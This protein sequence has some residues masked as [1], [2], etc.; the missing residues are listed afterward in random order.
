MPL[1]IGNFKDATITITT[2]DTVSAEVD[3]GNDCD[4][5]QV[6]MPALT[7]CKVSVQVA[8]KTGGTFQ[9]LGNSQATETTAGSYSTMFKLGGY[10]Y[11]KLVTSAGQSGNRT[12]RVR[13]AKS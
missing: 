1:Y 6:I 11:I 3:L 13:G 2:S 9:S 7:S 12:F 10:Q 8:E 5:L 4:L